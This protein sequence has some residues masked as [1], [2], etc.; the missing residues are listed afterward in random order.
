MEV[1]EL[2]SKG[3]VEGMCLGWV[4]KKFKLKVTEQTGSYQSLEDGGKGEIVI[5]PYKLSVIR[6]LIS[7]DLVYSMMT[8]ASSNVL[9][10]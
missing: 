1:S 8:V 6:R 9:H 3:R 7:G 2:D 10:T 4:K 5:K